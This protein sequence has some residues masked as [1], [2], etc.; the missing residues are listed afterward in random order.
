MNEIKL[1]QPDSDEI[2][3]D[4][5]IVVAR[6]ATLA[7]VDRATHEGALLEMKALRGAEK[8][9]KERL[10]PIIK[11]ANDAHKG[12]T[13]LRADLLR[14][15]E[16]VFAVVDGRCKTFEA[17]ERAKAEAEQR[18]LQDEARVREE[19]RQLLDAIAAE[20]S[21]DQAQAAAILEEKPTVPVVYVAPVLAKVT[22]VSSTEHWSA[23]V[24]DFPA[25]VQ[26]VASHLEL[27]FVVEAAMPQ[28][29]VLARS[30]R[31]ALAIPGVRAVST[32]G[33]NVR[34]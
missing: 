8:K 15:I 21:G 5:E 20:E 28:L 10:D 23:E 24:Y 27:I 12:L 13:K 17:T 26:H 7:V 34:G 22:G 3:R 30:Q 11:S 14:P 1:E 6:C 25:L 29:N 16:Q 32:Q 33:R 9:V 4:Y 18:R 19:E 31:K 2:K